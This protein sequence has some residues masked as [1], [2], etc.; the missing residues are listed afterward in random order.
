MIV[1]DSP[2]QLAGEISVVGGVAFSPKGHVCS[3]GILLDLALHLDLQVTAI[4]RSGFYQH[5]MI[6]QLCPRLADVV[7]A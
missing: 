6:H 7:H 4:A 3:L 5:C 2:N 1:E